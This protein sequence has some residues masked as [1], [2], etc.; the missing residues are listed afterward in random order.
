LTRLPSGRRVVFPGLDRRSRS[1]ERSGAV[2]RGVAWTVPGSE[3]PGTAGWIHLGRGRQVPDRSRSRSL[4]RVTTSA[5]S[6][7]TVRRLPGAGRRRGPVRRGRPC[8]PRA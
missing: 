4:V 2:R 3:R 7:R 5:R 1:R 8:R 6:C